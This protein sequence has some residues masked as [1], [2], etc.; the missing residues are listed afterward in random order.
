M[1]ITVKFNDSGREPQEKPDPRFPNGVDLDASKGADRACCFNLPYP[2]PRVGTYSVVC[3]DCKF[4]ALITVAGRADD[5]RSV[6]LPCK[7]RPN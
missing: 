5:P 6:K 7:G 2:A 1:T 3:D 4:T